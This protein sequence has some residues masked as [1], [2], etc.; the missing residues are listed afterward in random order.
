[1]NRH[2]RRAAQAQGVAAEEQVDV[3]TALASLEAA[4]TQKV[5]SMKQHADRG[6]DLA[7]KLAWACMAQQHEWLRV[8]SHLVRMQHD[9]LTSHHTI[10]QELTQKGQGQ[11]HG[12]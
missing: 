9:G 10:I 1:M 12:N 5:N 7:M 2:Q 3:G 11:G 4:S 6:G 8:M